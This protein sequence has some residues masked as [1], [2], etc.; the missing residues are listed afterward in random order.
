[1]SRGISL[2]LKGGGV[3]HTAA[4]LTERLEKLGRLATVFSPA[5]VDRYGSP[6]LANQGCA[7]LAQRNVVVV[8]IDPEVRPV[9][10]SLEVEVDLD[11]MPDF[12]AE[13]ILAKLAAAGVI[14]PETLGRSSEGEA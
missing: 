7:Y 10:E 4:V 5:T 11:D 8:V 6:E 12:A 14:D 2:C 3:V 13:K 1:M 9:G